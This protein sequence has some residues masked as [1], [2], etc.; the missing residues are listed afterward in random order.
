M[1]SSKKMPPR[2]LKSTKISIVT[3]PKSPTP[4]PI[5]E[6]EVV[7]EVEEEVVDD[8]LRSERRSLVEPQN[9]PS[10]TP[11]GSFLDKLD[12]SY[13]TRQEIDHITNILPEWKS[14][15]HFIFKVRLGKKDFNTLSQEER[16]LRKKLQLRRGRFRSMLHNPEAFKARQAKLTEQLR[17]RRKNKREEEKKQQLLTEAKE[18]VS[19][20]FNTKKN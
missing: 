20:Y 2:G 11:I 6:E 17:I 3:P 1:K 5:E 14:L 15:N 10:V 19:E 9:S 18:Y 16:L 13:F 4:E 12:E 8:S 7:E